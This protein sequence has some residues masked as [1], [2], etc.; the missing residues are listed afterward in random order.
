MLL[1]TAL[2]MTAFA[3]NSVLNRMGVA[4]GADAVSFGTLRLCSGAA[5]LAALCLV[6]R[7]GLPRRLPAGGGGALAL[8]LYIYGFSAA[9]GALNAGLGALILFGTVQITMFAGAAMRGD[10]VPPR[11][12]L[13]AA[14]AF[15]GLAWLL[16]PSGSFS[17]S[18]PHG[19]A[20]VAAGI[21]WGLYSLAGRGARDPLLTTATNFALAAPAGLLLWW[22]SPAPAA[23]DATGAALAVVSGAVTSGLGYALWYAVLPKLSAAGAAVSQLTVPLIATAG[24]VLLL[25]E[26]PTPRFAVAA[27]LVLGGLGLSIR[28]R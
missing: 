26:A 6:Q 17:V 24:G 14:V 28:R 11:S 5:M 9:Y 13:G 2:T 1:L 19:A 8:L 27:V 18:L 3:A 10:R 25:G 16:W 21:G 7:N 4:G 12:R 23:M 22:L 20:M 15:A